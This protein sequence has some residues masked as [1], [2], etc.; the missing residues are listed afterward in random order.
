M[1][2]ARTLGIS[3]EQF[4]AFV[5]NLPSFINLK[6]RDG[7]YLLINKNHSEL[8]G[9]P[10]QRVVGKVISEF[11]PE[12]QADA[13]EEQERQVTETKSVVTR[14]RRIVV[15]ERERTFLITKFPIFDDGGAVAQIGTIGTDISLLTEAQAALMAAT[16]EAEAANRSKSEF[17]A[18]MSHDLR[19]PLKTIIGF[20]DA[21]KLQ[22]FRPIGEKY[23]EYAGDIRGSG[24]HLLSLIGDILDVTAIEA[25]Q[26]TLRPE[27]MA[28]RSLIDECLT[29]I[30]GE[31]QALGIEIRT[32]VPADLPLLHADR[33]AF[34]KIVL[35]LLANSLTYTPRGG[36][37]T[38]SARVT[39]A[40]H[41]LEVRDTGAGIPENQIA[42]IT[43][44]F[45]RG[46]VDPYISHEG[47]GLG[48]AIVK[49]LVDLH[50]GALEIQSRIGAGTIVRVRFQRD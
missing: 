20:A 49:S 47:V 30:K 14:E 35:N 1:E 27:R 31:A 9:F 33:Q 13:A 36:R 6:D 3:G 28:A 41:V 8:F 42:R 25:G 2:S 4:C 39:K 40:H 23:R 7:H 38:L 11:L 45:F 46:E 32:K 16:A 21:I 22:Y 50:G 48:L 15:G 17:L 34:K 24:E 19:I 18:A 5:D 44:P 26:P 29:I 43:D 37:V 12:R 10:Q